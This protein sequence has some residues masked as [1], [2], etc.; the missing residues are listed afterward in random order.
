[1]IESYGALLKTCLLG[2]E[3]GCGGFE[4]PTPCLSSMC[5]KPTEL[6]THYFKNYF[7]ADPPDKSGCSKPTELTTLGFGFAKVIIF[8][9]DFYIF[10]A[11]FK[12]MK[13]LIF[14][15]LVSFLLAPGLIR[16]QEKELTLTDIFGIRLFSPKTIS[17]LTHMNDGETYCVLEGDSI[18]LYSYESGEYIRTL[19][20]RKVLFAE[21]D[22][23]P[24]RLEDFTFSRDEKK[25]L[26]PTATERI[27]RYSSIS[28]FYVYDFETRRTNHLSFTGKQ[29]LAT[30][31]PDGTK[32]AFV[33]DNNLNVTDLVNNIEVQ[34]TH[35]GKKNEIINGTT[36][37]VYE[38]EFAIT[39]GFEWSPDGNRIAFFRFDESKVP[40]FSMTEWGE[41]YPKANNF[42]YPKAG[43]DNSEVTIHIY[44]VN[45]Q[46]TIPVDLGPETDQYF[47]RFFWTKDPNKLIVLKLNRLQNALDILLVDAATGKSDV[48]YHEDNPYY[49]EESHFDNFI[50]I[51]N[52]R[53]LMTSEK[54]GYY[55]IYLNNLDKSSKFVQLTDGTW[56]VTKVHGYDPATGLVW[57]SAATSSPINRELWTVDLKGKMKQVSSEPGTHVP[58]FSKT[59][60]YYIN[61]FSD[62]NTPPVYTVNRANGKVIRTIE[63]NQALR[64][65]MKE[66]NFSK[67]EFFTFKTPEGIELNGWKILPPDFSPD[68]KY[69]VLMDVYGGPGSQTV[70]N[71]Y[72]AGDYTWYQMLAGKGYIV[73]SVDN[74]GTGSRGQ[75]FKKMTYLQLGKL[76]T[77]DQM[78]AAKYL[79]SQSY[80]DPTR[81]GIWGWSYGGFMSTSC[82]TKGA[83]VFKMAIA[84]APV[85]NWRY[86]D[87]I[88]T[89]R[90]MRKPQDNPNGYD[91]NSPINH[92]G[93]MTGKYL[94]IHGTADDNVHVQNTMDLLTALNKADKQYS[95]FLYP[96]K[97]HSIYGGNTR[98]HLYTLMTNFILENL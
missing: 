73:V 41:L 34:F 25:L 43:E 90:F 78:A 83:G 44:N 6:T 4:P 15:I 65:K 22:T 67:K 81:I 2:S 3:V 60:K 54:S 40:E 68:K 98:L 37:W 5:S 53:Y 48:V 39:Q 18:N 96:N 97:N 16:A 92:V 82:I 28:E 20:F 9:S 32:V 13:K 91:D 17:G 87:N 80:V 94:V 86:Y 89:E 29:R 36:D 69:P 26:I 85:T 57:F 33:R 58:Q 75:E 30:F 12:S 56:D 61:N 55:H 49:I 31:S 27:Y 74:R 84:V 59:F 63:D 19:V 64:Q 88:Y 24:I 38:E 70:L 93:K 8:Y 46:M 47:P 66:Y 1:V 11:I 62:A 52:N 50:F 14:L 76:E 79:A 7:Y 23:A 72:R 35:D 10:A 42:K 77:F 45:T 95:M 71:A 51:D 21:N